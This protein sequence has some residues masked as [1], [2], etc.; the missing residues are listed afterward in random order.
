MC[1]IFCVLA[2]SKSVFLLKNCSILRLTPWLL[3][4][5]NILS[6]MWTVV[7][8]IPECHLSRKVLDTICLCVCRGRPSR[9]SEPLSIAASSLID[10]H[11][12]LDGLQYLYISLCIKNL[13]L[14]TQYLYMIVF[15]PSVLISLWV[16]E[17]LVTQTVYK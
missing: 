13:Y 1:G 11:L 16:F 4:Y 7:Y 14:P 12:I 10:N 9:W 5:Q 3:R 15:Q 6:M 17:I 8:S 2:L